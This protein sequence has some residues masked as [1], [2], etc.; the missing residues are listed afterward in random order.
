M[1]YAFRNASNS[2]AVE[3]VVSKMAKDGW[4][5]EYLI[6]EQ[7]RFWVLFGKDGSAS[8]VDEIGA[9]Y[10]EL[11]IL[12]DRVHALETKKVEKQS[13]PKKEN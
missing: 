12:A 10:E 8:S 13:K 2:G 1:E 6:K 3:N 5:V 11:N 9:V 7:H 4:K